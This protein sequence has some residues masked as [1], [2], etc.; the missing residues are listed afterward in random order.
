MPDDRDLVITIAPGVLSQRV[1]DETVLL[2]PGREVY[3]GLDEVGSAF[4]RLLESHRR[5]SAIH[6]VLLR[7]Y[8]VAPDRLWSDLDALVRDL[9]AHALV[10]VERP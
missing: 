8:D 3:F 6:G 10:T 1:A 4:W 9:E 5:L 2:D 7:R